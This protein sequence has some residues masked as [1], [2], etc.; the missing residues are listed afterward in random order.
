MYDVS[1]DDATSIVK[2]DFAQPNNQDILSV[3]LAANAWLNCIADCGVGAGAILDLRIRLIKSGLIEVHSWCKDVRNVLLDLLATG[4][5]EA[6]AEYSLVKRFS[7][8][9]R[10]IALL[11]DQVLDGPLPVSILTR[12]TDFRS[13]AVHCALQ[14]L[15]FLDRFTFSTEDESKM[16]RSLEKFKD[17]NK[18]CKVCEYDWGSFPGGVLRYL[19]ADEF[20]QLLP[21]PFAYNIYDANFSDGSVCDPHPD[22]WSGHQQTKLG[23]FYSLARYELYYCRDKRYPYPLHCGFDHPGSN[24]KGHYPRLQCVPKSLG[25]FRVIAP[26]SS[27]NSFM[28]GAALEAL[29]RALRAS[30]AMRYINERDQS[31]NRTLALDSSST[32]SYATIDLSS[33]S[34]TISK[35]VFHSV[36][37]RWYSNFISRFESDWIEVPSG[38][39]SYLVKLHTLFTS[40]NRLTWLNEAVYFLAIARAAARFCAPFCGESPARVKIYAYGDDLIVPSWAY[41]TVCDFLRV[42]GHIVNDDKSYNTGHFRESCGVWAYKGEDV[43]PL[44]WPRAMLEDKPHIVLTA[45]DLQHK[46][47]EHEFPRMAEYC[48]EFARAHHRT[49]TTSSVGSPYADLWDAD[50]DE[51]FDSTHKHTRLTDGKVVIDYDDLAAHIAYYQ[52][53]QYGPLYLSDEDREQGISSSRL[54]ELLTTNRCVKP[55]LVP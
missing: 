53:L 7:G 47:L 42:F 12:F 26:E 5:E 33:A 51:W 16:T 39:D 4:E 3:Q 20:L 43:T 29:R 19:V 52:Y 25:D 18:L 46:A 32:G 34:D 48:A 44:F 37:P 41:D 1:F 13:A 49:M 9:R 24:R 31:V 15:C 45:A 55:R 10:F 23:K 8:Q 40:G 21:K 22:V 11:V 35:S 36:A 30:G 17:A 6:F 50:V 2:R 38:K 14:I 54:Q 27:Y 28:G